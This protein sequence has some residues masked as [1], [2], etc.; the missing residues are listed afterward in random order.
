MLTQSSSESWFWAQLSA[1]ARAQ[2]GGHPNSWPCHTP[3]YSGVE[4]RTGVR[5]HFMALDDTDEISNRDQFTL[6]YASGHSI[7]DA[8][9]AAGVSRRTGYRWIKDP[10]VRAQINET[11]GEIRRETVDLLAGLTASAIECLRRVL[12][13]TE[14][15]PSVQVRAAALV[16]SESRN[17]FEIE[18]LRQRIEALESHPGS[19][20]RE[21]IKRALDDDEEET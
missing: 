7:G 11:R 20:L 1:E 15:T 14:L 2:A 13:D 5:C 12:S 19:D 18:E 21:E 9:S 6:A 16:L 10:T 3:Q 4:K 17:W 8:A